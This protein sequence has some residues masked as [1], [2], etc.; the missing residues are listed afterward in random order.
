MNFTVAISKN[1][2]TK[3]IISAKILERVAISSSRRSSQPRYQSQ[4][5]CGLGI[6][7]CI[8]YRWATWEALDVSEVGAKVWSRI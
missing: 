3:G 5:S 8:L 7:K 1:H 4:V 2:S 6:D